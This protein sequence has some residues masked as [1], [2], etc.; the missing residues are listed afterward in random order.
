VDPL[1]PFALEQYFARWEFRAP[2]HLTASDGETMTVAELLALAGDDAREKLLS[3]PLGYVPTWGGRALREAVAARYRGLGPD[4][5]LAF[6]GAE[7]AIFWALQTLLGPGDHAVVTV[8]SY[9]ALE[10]VPLAT[11]AVV[12]GVP[13]WTGAGEA[14]RWTL[15]VDR[16]SSALRSNTR[17][18][19]VNFPNNPTG[20]VPDVAS[21][22]ALGAL[23]E[24]RGLVLFADEVYRGL[25][26]DPARTLKP[27]A[28]LTARGLSLDVTSKSLG[29]PGLRVGWLACRDRALLARL[30]GAK[31][32][33]SICNAGPS[34]LLATIA[35]HHADELRGRIEAVIRENTRTLTAF[36][37]EH[38]ELFDWAPPD[39]GCVAFPRYRGREGVERMCAELVEHRGVM[40]LPASLFRS[41]LAEVP[42]DRFRIGLGRRQLAPALAQFHEYLV[43]RP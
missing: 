25:E 21:W 27:A 29:L 43:A 11:G 14:L 13:L 9:Q 32:W 5:V 22:A 4:D 36:F 41:R 3:L 7:E 1:P 40:L 34:E 30:E 17:V 26:P 31:H 8:P 2:H 38:G 12:T 10:A 33:T 23:C 37:A 24:R 15:D 35:V 28:E 19:V 20:F 18:V 16:V 42:I 39:G 6:A